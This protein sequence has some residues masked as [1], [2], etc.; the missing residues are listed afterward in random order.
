VS[1]IWL[2]NFARVKEYRR[3]R[4]KDDFIIGKRK[5]WS[6]SEVYSKRR[7][8][9][10]KLRIYNKQEKDENYINVYEKQGDKSIKNKLEEEERKT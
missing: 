4:A 6:E 1:H 5:N 8:G 7:G 10:C 3:K 9:H 2:Y